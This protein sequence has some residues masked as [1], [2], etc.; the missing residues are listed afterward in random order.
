MFARFIAVG[1]INTIVGYSLFAFFIY[2]GF[3]YTVAVLLGTILGVLFNFKTI[4]TLVFRNRNNLLIF[5]FISV[6]AIT[7]VINIGLLKLMSFWLSNMYLAGF[8]LIFPMAI[9]TFILN[10]HL[11][12]KHNSAGITHS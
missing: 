9:T 8:I 5:K 11:V 6:Y 3:H 2:I 1:V 7:Y 12:F 4:G 10:K